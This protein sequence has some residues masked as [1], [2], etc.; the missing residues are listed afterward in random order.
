[1]HDVDPEAINAETRPEL[2]YEYRDANWGSVWK[3][4]RWFVGFGTVMVILSIFIQWWFTKTR[5]GE[6]FRPAHTLRKPVEPNPLLQ[7][8]DA[9]KRDIVEMRRAAKQKLNS[10]GYESNTSQ[11]YMPLDRAMEITAEKGLNPPSEAPAA[12]K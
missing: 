3:V 11:S 9:A 1:M 12:P 8:G 5:P 7:S 10:Y 6:E 4:Y 2:G